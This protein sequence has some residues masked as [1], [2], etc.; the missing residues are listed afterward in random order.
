MKNLLIGAGRT[1]RL[2]GALLETSAYSL[3]DQVERYRTRWFIRSEEGIRAPTEPS[4][5]SPKRAAFK[6]LE[7]PEAIVD[8]VTV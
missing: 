1:V 5:T 8:V 4:K 3:P 7:D 2:V 6:G